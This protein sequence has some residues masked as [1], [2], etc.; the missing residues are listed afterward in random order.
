MG[1]GNPIA[2][3]AAIERTYEDTCNI[4][5][6]IPVTVNNISKSQETTVVS[7]AICALSQRSLKP[8]NQTD[9][10]NEIEYDIKLFIS[11]DIPV[12]AG[13]VITVKRFGRDNPASTIML[14]FESASRPMIYP[15]HQEVMLKERGQA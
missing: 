2:E 3:R 10:Q 12:E 11:P 8:T 5:R 15:T 7:N 9:A 4:V 6:M 14:T 1:F 13:D